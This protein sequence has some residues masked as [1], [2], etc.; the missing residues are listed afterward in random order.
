MSS[1]LPR[2]ILIE[3]VSD[4]I[5]PFCYVGKRR[6]EKAMQT[7]ADKR[8]PI[9]FDVQF[10][11]FMLDPK[12]DSYIGKFGED[13]V[14]NM[15]KAM[16]DTGRSVGINFSYEGLIANTM[17]SHRLLEYAKQEG[18]QSTVVDAVFNAYFE[19]AQNL[20]DRNVLADA[21]AKGGLDRDAVLRYLESD[22]GTHEVLEGL[23]AA[24]RRRITGV[25]F[26]RIDRGAYEISGA[27]DESVFVEIFEDLAKKAASSPSP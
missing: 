5:C 15:I 7:V 17:D 10:K 24:R 9:T 3:I 11:P 21:G 4:N 12:M 2:K 27:Q 8:L 13:R 25:P 14:K 6:L 20:G 19:N 18:K 1:V 16:G 22:E 26:F 23:D